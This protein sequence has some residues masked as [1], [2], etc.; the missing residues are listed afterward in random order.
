MYQGTTLRHYRYSVLDLSQYYRDSAESPSPDHY[1]SELHGLD[2]ASGC[3]G[4][5]GTAEGLTKADGP[6]TG[7][8]G[9]FAFN[10]AGRRSRCRPLR[11][12]KLRMFSS[13]LTT[14]SARL[15]RTAINI[16]RDRS[17]G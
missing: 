9:G 11:R 7:G 15:F 6:P 5:D 16:P 1:T 4:R 17:S 12:V 2:N 13:V 14:K 3:L 8:G 10:R